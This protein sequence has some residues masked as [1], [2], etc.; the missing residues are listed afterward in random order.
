MAGIS[1]RHMSLRAI[2]PPCRPEDVAAR[3]WKCSYCGASGTMEVLRA[4]VCSHVYKACEY[5]GSPGPDG[6]C[7][8]T[9]AGI[10]AILGAPEVHLVGMAKPKLPK[11]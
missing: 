5:C 4:S 2:S 11:A 9:C 8:L 10:A 3:I 1:K 7:S 6:D